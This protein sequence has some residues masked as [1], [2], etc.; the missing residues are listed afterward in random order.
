MR[1]EGLSKAADVDH[2]HRLVVKPELLH[3]TISIVS[4]R[5]EP[6]RRRRSVRELEHGALA[7]MHLGTTRAP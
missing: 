2:H 7:I 6:A 5:P 3:V 4:S 1:R